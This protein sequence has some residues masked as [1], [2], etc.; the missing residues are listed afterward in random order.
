M[1]LDLA[2]PYVAVLLFLRERPDDREEPPLL[3]YIELGLN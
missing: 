2:Y 3:Y 1:A